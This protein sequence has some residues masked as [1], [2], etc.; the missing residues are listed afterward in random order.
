MNVEVPRDVDDF[1]R[2]LVV[3]G[4]YASEQDAVAEAFRLLKSREQLRV[5]CTHFAACTACR[6]AG[7]CLLHGPF[8]P[9]SSQP[10][11]SR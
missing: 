9:F 1:V 4:R 7:G 10:F 5:F 3:A 11:P 6:F 2:K 8:A